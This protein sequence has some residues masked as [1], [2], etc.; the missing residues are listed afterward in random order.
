MGIG[1][2]S[3]FQLNTPIYVGQSRELMKLSEVEMRKAGFYQGDIELLFT[4]Q[5]YA[6][7]NPQI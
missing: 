4:Q 3:C 5:L 2:F 1:T 7:I 6:Y